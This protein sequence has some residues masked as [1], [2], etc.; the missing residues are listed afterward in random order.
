VS[1][2]SFAD[3]S[4]GSARPLLVWLIVQCPEEFSA[5]NWASY[6]SGFLKDKIPSLSP[7]VQKMHPQDTVGV[8]HWCDNATLGVDLLPTAD[9]AA[10]ISSLQSVLS[11]P[12]ARISDEPGI[13]ALISMMKRVHEV[14]RR[15]APGSRPVLVFFYG[16][17]SGMYRDDA[18]A[19]L[20]SLLGDSAIV[21]CVNNGAVAFRDTPVTN[22]IAQQYVIHFFSNK[23]GGEVLSS[24]HG[25]Y[26]EA[27]EQIVNELHGRYQFGLAPKDMDGA[28]HTFDVKLTR[29]AREKFKHVDVRFASSFVAASQAAATPEAK[30]DA[31]IYAAIRDPNPMTQIPFDASGKIVSPGQPAQF[32]LY[33]AP[34]ALSWNP[35]PNGDRLTNFDLIEAAISAQNAVLSSK[36]SQIQ[37]TQTKAEQAAPH[38]GAVLVN[39]S[40]PIPQ[41]ASR[42]RFV[43]LDPTSGHIGTWDV[44]VAQIAGSPPA[45]P[46]P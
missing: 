8:A 20:K 1:I 5:V 9:R 37:A 33:V 2:S 16:D 35:Q 45:A 43:I 21:Y 24:W 4:T 39:I 38:P 14:S 28:I 13:D 42:V 36:A 23:T 31:A 46:A 18:D 3:A 27:L 26:G 40:F 32:R 22:Q 15:V 25:E 12:M 17:H 19:L 41:S 34:A 44:P 6:G 29:E 7:A 30:R 10:P 11:A